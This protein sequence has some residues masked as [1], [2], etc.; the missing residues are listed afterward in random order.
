MK[1]SDFKILLE[2]LVHTKLYV[3]SKITD[4]QKDNNERKTCIGLYQ[5]KKTLRKATPSCRI[6]TTGGEM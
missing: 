3:S 1:I 5:G 2:D 4:E 6:E